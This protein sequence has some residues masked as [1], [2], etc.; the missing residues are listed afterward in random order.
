MSALELFR[1]PDQR[2]YSVH[3]REQFLPSLRSLVAVVTLACAG[4]ALPDETPPACAA[5]G[6]R[7]WEFPA[8][9]SRSLRVWL[10]ARAQEYDG[11]GPYGWRR[12]RFA[13]D[14]WNS[15]RL[16]VRFT[17]ARSARE[18]DIIVDIIQS[19]PEQDDQARDQAAV[20][21]L[22]YQ[23]TGEII[24]ARVL[25]AVTPP[26]GIG[27]YSVLDQQANL[28]HE[29]GHAIGLPHVPETGAV[30]ATRR[31]SH[32]VTGA[33]IALARTHYAV[34]PAPR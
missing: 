1:A 27:R 9:G 30:M 24:R 16:P 31:T 23:P 29:L 13:M 26:R 4:R 22:T 2:K 14:E 34:C 20:T 7:R 10:D 5:P 33:D 32:G 17:E 11:W 19:I 28:L 18:S 6:L 8:V 3:V 12:L 25:I 15:I 21:N